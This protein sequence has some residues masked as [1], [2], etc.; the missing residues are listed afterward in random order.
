MN[1][2]S[3]SFKV[4]CAFDRHCKQGKRRIVITFFQIIKTLNSQNSMCTNLLSSLERPFEKLVD[5]L[6]PNLKEE[7]EDACG[8]SEG[9]F[10]GNIC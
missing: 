10:E 2:C 9:V 7:Y 4:I 5:S 6:G 1:R 3:L 8:R